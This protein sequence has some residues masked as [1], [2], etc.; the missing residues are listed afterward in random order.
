M[1]NARHP[2]TRICTVPS[3][4]GLRANTWY[5]IVNN[6]R[7][8]VLFIIKYIKILFSNDDLF[9]YIYSIKVHSTLGLSL[10]RTPKYQPL[11]ALMSPKS[12]YGASVGIVFWR[13]RQQSFCILFLYC[14][15]LPVR[16]SQAYAHIITTV[17]TVLTIICWD[18]SWTL[19]SFKTGL[20][21]S[22]DLYF[23]DRRMNTRAIH[24]TPDIIIPTIFIASK[25]NLQLCFWN[26]SLHV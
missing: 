24:T 14:H 1:F 19:P 7:I 3:S 12:R 25:M 23:P 8:L 26:L 5:S 21:I 22:F 4:S 16:K 17:R 6:T 2:C 15:R 10:T 18:Q 13:L 20:V 11:A 9:H